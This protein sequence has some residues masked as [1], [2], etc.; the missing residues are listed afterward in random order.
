MDKIELSPGLGN[1]NLI[2]ITTILSAYTLYAYM[3][4][5]ALSGYFP[6]LNDNHLK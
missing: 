6:L 2:I 3:Y 4:M 1:L 5:S